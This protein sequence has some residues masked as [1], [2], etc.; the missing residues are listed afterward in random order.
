M[1]D[2]Q[3]SH[4]FYNEV[5]K[6]VGVRAA[7]GKGNRL[8][9]IDRV[10]F[11]VLLDKRSIASLLHFCRDFIQRLIPGNIFPLRSARAAYL[12]LD[13]AAVIQ[14]VLLKGGTLGAERAAVDGMVRIAFNVNHLR[15]N[16]LRPVADRVY[17]DAAADRAIG[18]CRAG[19]ACSCDFQAAKFCEGGL[20]IE[21]ENCGCR[22]TN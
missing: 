1:D 19:L 21:S 4:G 20:K 16:V 9:A 7:A 6:F 17:D 11:G 22:A 3:A 14:N 15:G 10:A 13:D 8:T 12:R 2:T 18:T 5:V